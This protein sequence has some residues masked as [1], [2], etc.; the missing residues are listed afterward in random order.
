MNTNF[1]YEEE[2][3][4]VY[5]PIIESSQKTVSKLYKNGTSLYLYCLTA[6]NINNEIDLNY[7]KVYEI[8]N[9]NKSTFYRMKKTLI[10]LEIISKL[11]KNIYLFDINFGF[12]DF[13][14][15][16]KFDKDVSFTNLY[17]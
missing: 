8:T 4:T 10:E 15:C 5:I 9:I 17:I 3:T 12:K 2:I 13:K 1:I 16:Q 11:N 14:N 6:M 7:K